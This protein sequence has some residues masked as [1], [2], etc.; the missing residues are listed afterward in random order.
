MQKSHAAFRRITREV[1]DDE[2]SSPVAGK[3]LLA[4]VDRLEEENHQLRNYQERFHDAD[5]RAALLE[6]RV[7]T[8]IS[9]EFVSASGLAVGAAAL[10]YAPAVWA[11]PPT[12][13]IAL[14]FGSILIILGV[15]A[16]VAR[17]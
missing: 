1:T 8:N 3:F 17:T 6:N 4:E 16:K 12:G 13:W 11:S 14:A 2:L 15:V 7:R 10:G 9:G 5:K